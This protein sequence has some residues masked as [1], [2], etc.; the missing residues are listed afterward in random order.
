[1]DCGHLPFGIIK[2]LFISRD[3]FGEKPLYYHLSDKVFFGSE[4]KFIKSLS[5]ESF[6][7]NKEYINKNLFYGY[8]SLCKNNETF[9][10]KIYSLEN[11]TNITIDLNLNLIKENFGHRK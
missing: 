3:I 1:M 2:K 6:K 4:I 11:S 10:D 5:N 8:K 9:F 7:V